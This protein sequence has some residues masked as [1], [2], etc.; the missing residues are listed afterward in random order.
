M[1]RVSASFQERFNA[2][3]DQALSKSVPESVIA[4]SFNLAEP[5]RIE[6]VGS[7]TFSDDDPDWAC[8]PEAFRAKG[9][10]LS[11]PESEVGSDW[12]S[13]LEAAK[14]MVSAYLARESPGQGRLRKAVVVVV[15][16]VDGDLHKV[17][18]A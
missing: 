18:P 12:E 2:W 8:P 11:L 10:K 5:W 1:K 14:S 9:K 17:W 16:F 13:V 7:N 3:V 4:F 6:L 15:G